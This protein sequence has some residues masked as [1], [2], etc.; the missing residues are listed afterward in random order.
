MPLRLQVG[1]CVCS[2]LEVLA[3]V[4][5]QRV[6]HFAIAASRLDIGLAQQG[7]EAVDVSAE[8]RE[9]CAGRDQRRDLVGTV[10]AGHQDRHAIDQTAYEVSSGHAGMVRGFDRGTGL[11][12]AHAQAKADAVTGID[13]PV[14]RRTCGLLS[15]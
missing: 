8:G 11:L 4:L 7:R 2:Q 13:A 14:V 12:A 5:G 15:A 1:K 10:A 3:H 6:E 9:F